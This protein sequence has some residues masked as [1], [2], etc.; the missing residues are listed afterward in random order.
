MATY[1]VWS[2]ATGAANGSSWTDAYTSLGN[3]FTG[4]AIAGSDV[5][6]IASDHDN[7]S[8]GANQSF[9][10]PESGGS[11]SAHVYLVSTDRVSGLPSPG[12]IE[13]TGGDFSITLQGRINAYG[14]TFKAGS[15]GNES[16]ASIKLGSLSNT[17]Y[18]KPIYTACDFIINSTSTSAFVV[19]GTANSYINCFEFNGCDFSFANLQQGFSYN[20]T[21]AEFNNCTLSGT[22]LIVAFQNNAIISKITLRGCDFSSATTLTSSTSDHKVEL[23][24]VNAL[25]PAF[26]TASS[27]VE[28]GIFDVELHSCGSTDHSYFYQKTVHEGTVDHDV[29]VYLTTGGATHKDNDGSSVQ[30]S[31]KMTGAANAYNCSK[32][33]PL[34]TP[35]FFVPVFSTGSKTLSIKVAHEQASV[36]KDNEIWMEVEYMGGTATI[37][38]PQTVREITAPLISGTVFQDYQSAGSN[39]TDTTEAWTGLASEKTHTLNKTVTIDEQGYARVRVALAVNNIAVYVNPSVAVA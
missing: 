6:L 37:N 22:A 32:S 34:Y 38:T 27:I 24:A 4:S 2:G 39:L 23:L 13:Q 8:Y 28:A 11:T 3:L 1:Y 12:A 36:L 35:W 20:N 10:F 29:A 19:L 5:I 31:L 26:L 14:L 15:G 18:G 16:S 21:D 33:N 7:G 30:Y 25:L 17:T 9:T